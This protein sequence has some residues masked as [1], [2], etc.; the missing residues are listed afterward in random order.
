MKIQDR[1]QFHQ[2]DLA[3]LCEKPEPPL[4][5]LTWINHQYGI[6]TIFREYAGLP[7]DEPLAFSIDH[8]VPTEP[9]LE[10]DADF[11]HGLPVFMN[12]YPERAAH[13]RNQGI[14]RAIPAALTIHYAKALLARQGWK[15]PT[16][17][18]GTL[19]FPHKSAARTDRVFDFHAYGKWLAELPEE[20]QPACVCIFWK[21]YLQNRHLPY[22]ELGL[23]VVTCGHFYHTDFLFR[24]VDLCSQFRYACSNSLASSYPLSVVCGC[25]FIHKDVGAIQES[26]RNAGQFETVDPGGQ[27]QYGPELRKLAPYPPE[28]ALLAKQRELSDFLTGAADFKSPEEIREL[29]QWARD[30]LLERQ[31]KR[32]AFAKKVELPEFNTWLPANIHPDGWAAAHSHFTV[33]AESTPRTLR[34]HLKL[35]P[36]ISET[37]QSLALAVNDTEQARFECGPGRYVVTLPLPPNAPCKVAFDLPLQVDLSG[38]GNRLVG[39][40]VIGWE[41]ITG[42]ERE[43][44][45]IR[46]KRREDLP[47]LLQEAGLW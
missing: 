3:R 16:E 29:Q 20:F 26:D 47:P 19:A 5:E 30:W 43:V 10:F 46:L 31:P 9:T 42:T 13:Y 44:T 15:A 28:D 27:F 34:I 22:L 21:D 23:P 11:A 33:R 25:Q 35:S 32:V 45:C 14:P 24:F 36:K 8:G 37:T 1:L 41:V 6:G 7:E 4:R 17:R 40:R 2:D 18:K 38:E 39:M 12:A